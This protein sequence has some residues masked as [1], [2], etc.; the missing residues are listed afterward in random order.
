MTKVLGDEVHQAGSQVEENR[1]RFD[2]TFSR[3]MTPDEI[4]KTEDI[5]NSWI[6]QGL[7]VTTQEMDIEQ[8]KLTGAVAL[9]G[10]KYEDVVRV[11]SMGT[12]THCISKEFCAGTHARNTRDLRLFKIVSEGAISAGTRRIEVVVSKAAFEFM[13][14]KVKEM[15]KLSLMFK[16]HYDEVMER[17]EKLQEENKELQKHLANAQEENARAKFSTFLSRAED[18]DGGKLFISK[19]E[20]FDS[21]AV[22][23]GVE[24]LAK[25]LG[26]SIIVLVSGNMVI[27]S[28]T[29]GFIKKG[30]NAGK[31]VGEIARATG[32]KTNHS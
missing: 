27:A 23:A 16:V 14:A 17:V 1:M 11:V 31:I 4:F 7:D 29:D 24:L 26:E 15:D 2:F 20:E 28:V 10:E 22:K 13:N 9:F 32:A 3:A 8:A 5:V 19:I 6:S 21:K 18:I 25:K 12:P 30:Y